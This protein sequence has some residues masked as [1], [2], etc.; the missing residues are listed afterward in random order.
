MKNL[1]RIM[2]RA[3]IKVIAFLLV[4]IIVF[5]DNVDKRLDHLEEKSS[6]EVSR[7]RGDIRVVESYMNL[8][9]SLGGQMY[10]HI[11]DEEI[12][13]NAPEREIE[14]SSYLRL[15]YAGGIGDEVMERETQIA[16]SMLRY[17]VYVR[18]SIGGRTG[19]YYITRSGILAESF[20]DD[21]NPMKE[22]EDRGYVFSKGEDGSLQVEMRRHVVS[23]GRVYGILGAIIHPEFYHDRIMSIDIFTD[24]GELLYTTR[25]SPEKE[26]KPLLR[27]NSKPQR[28]GWEYR[29][30]Y[31][32]MG[33]RVYFSI[34]VYYLVYFGIIRSIALILVALILY[35]IQKETDRR[36]I[37]EG[38]K[39]LLIEDLKS[40][41]RKLE[42][43][44]ER[45]FLTGLYNRRGVLRHL[46]D[47]FS[48]SRRSGNPFVIILGD[49]DFFKRFNDEYGH[50]C[51][52][53]VLKGVGE[54]FR[55]HLRTSDI[56]G[57]WGGEEF[58]VALLDCGE[59]TGH[60]KAEVM[61]KEIE[62]L[63]KI[64]D[65]KELSIT[66]TMG[67]TEVDLEL[68]LEENIN[69]ADRAL[70]RGK[71]EGRNRVEIYGR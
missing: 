5:I 57:R 13:H 3:S 40:A 65:G 66:M 8:M 51:G 30:G 39:S 70:Y 37:I 63:R 12:H 20:M 64:Y 18:G 7:I 10:Y 58:I 21:L 16:L 29:W 25:V 1:G 4:Y 59:A 67:V 11:H 54:F 50:E 35:I 33:K 61:R 17:N 53:E 41:Q 6:V 55:G 15:S 32:L 24:E 36:R 34:P 60:E 43:T 46:R 42:E 23:E 27:L 2:D 71:E 44:S 31:N 19:M 52:D 49:I 68:S 45:D 14:T 48:R 69:L 22:S 47:E 56:C 28:T 26:R 9:G 38:E 62:S